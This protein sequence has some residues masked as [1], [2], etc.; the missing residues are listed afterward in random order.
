MIY[1]KIRSSV[2]NDKAFTISLEDSVYKLIKVPISTTYYVLLAR[3]YGL[4]YHEF[5]KMLRDEYGATITG[6]DSNFPIF[7]FEKSDKINILIAE[8]N[9]KMSKIF[10]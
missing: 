10:G 3:I 4:P 9:Q 8:L 2:A 5:L 1:F 7:F 6:K